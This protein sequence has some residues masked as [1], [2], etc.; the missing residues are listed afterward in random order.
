MPT[1]AEYLRLL[2]RNNVVA[3]LSGAGP[4][5]IAL[6]TE[7]ELPSKVLEYGAANGFTITAMTAGEGVRWSPGVT[8]PG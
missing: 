7:P 4:S 6:S 3:T 1:S 2:R 8:V 5:L